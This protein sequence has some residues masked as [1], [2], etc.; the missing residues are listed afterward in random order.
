MV[1]LN[2]SMPA[3][4]EGYHARWDCAHGQR[5]DGNYWR[6]EIPL[7]AQGHIIGRVE[8]IGERDH[9]PVWKKI[10]SVLELLDDFENDASSLVDALEP[11]NGASGTL[12]REDKAR[13]TNGTARAIRETA[14][15]Q[16][17]LRTLN[18]PHFP[19]PREPRGD[20]RGSE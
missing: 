5:E 2:V 14:V 20:K 6:T 18:M 19:A 8:I 15:S 7:L 17:V 4:H 10:V 12:N 1:R 13:Y 3:I 9:E 11:V 16:P